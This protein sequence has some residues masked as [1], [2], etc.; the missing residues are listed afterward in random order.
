MFASKCIFVFLYYRLVTKR[1]DRSCDQLA[2][3]EEN[4]IPPLKCLLSR[5]FW[6]FWEVKFGLQKPQLLSENLQRLCFT[7]VISETV[8]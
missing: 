6:N 4:F 5:K 8:E 2:T 3:Q 7:S 1:A